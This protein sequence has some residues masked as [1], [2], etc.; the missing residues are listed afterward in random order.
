MEAVTASAAG[1]DGKKPFRG[2]P[3][4]YASSMLDLITHVLILMVG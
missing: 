1:D 2:C 3:V 4:S